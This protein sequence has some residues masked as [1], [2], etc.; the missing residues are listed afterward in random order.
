M[1]SLSICALAVAISASA[2]PAHS[3]DLD[4]GVLR[5]SEEEYVA[6]ADWSGFYL[7]V[8]GG[9][10]T[11]SFGYGKAGQADLALILQGLEL[12]NQYGVSSSNKLRDS[13]AHNG[14]FGGFA[15]YNVQVDDVVFGIEVDYT[16][17]NQKG[18]AWGDLSRKA[19]LN[20]GLYDDYTIVTQA[21]AVLQDYGTVRGRVGYAFGSFLPY[22]TAGAAFGRALVGTAVHA[23][24]DEYTDIEGT[25]LVGHLDK[26]GGSIKEKYR[27]GAA[28]G[29]GGEY[30]F[31][32]NIFARAEYQY[33]LFDRF[34]DTSIN[35]STVRG[36]VGVKF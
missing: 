14:S 3:A 27:F 23:R 5:G 17:A 13:R 36:A 30:L 24:I 11:S 6:P 33:L 28:F 19:S 15:G 29:V 2:L 9:Y 8:H 21:R 25:N 34:G 12:E 16:S 18:E 35:V 20:S 10:T 1:R 7:G 26:G 31:T 22:V 32:Q 4:Y